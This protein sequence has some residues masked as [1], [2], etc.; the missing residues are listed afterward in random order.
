MLTPPW[1]IH[2]HLLSRTDPVSLSDIESILLDSRG[3]STDSD[4]H[5]FLNPPPPT[6][7]DLRTL[8]GLSIKSLDRAVSEIKAAIET[9]TPILI[10]GDYDCDG[11]CATAILYKAIARHT[12]LVHPFIPHRQHHGYGLSAVG[13]KKALQEVAARFTGAPL[14]ITVDNGISAGL[15]IAAL[16]KAGST[17]IVVDHHQ[18]PPTPPSSINIHSTLVCAATLSLLL[19]SSLEDSL[20]DYELASLATVTDQV[21]LL[22]INRSLVF[23]GLKN[24]RRTKSLGLR[25]LIAAQIPPDTPLDT[26]H[27]GFI[28]GPRINAAGRLDHALIALRLLLTEDPASARRL[29]ERLDD[30]NQARQDHTADHVAVAVSEFTALSTLPPVLLTSSPDYH[31]GII[32][33]IAAKLSD[34]FKRPAVAVRV[35]DVLKGSARSVKGV[36][37]T[38]LLKSLPIDFASIGGHEQAA[39]FSLSREYLDLL[40]NTLNSLQLELPSP[41]LDIDLALNPSQLSLA[42]F[43]LI[44]RF[45]PFGTDN[46]EPLLAISSPIKSLRLVGTSKQHLQ[47]RFDS[48]NISGGI[49]F[50]RPDWFTQISP[51][52]S[53]SLAFHLKHQIYQG[54]S[55]LSLQVR[56]ISQV[57]LSDMRQ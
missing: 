57:S 6:L 27:F 42:L 47:F 43:Q 23:H 37:I 16:Q 39:G 45:A 46:P 4:K 48:P 49:A 24:I 55:Q 26:Y 20:Q 52:R 11:V 7:E 36:D 17:V 2:H 33:L 35:G 22:G 25:T 40:K 44:A 21:P 32:G 51:G 9:K 54:N 14:V 28:I 29:V 18:L 3:L 41:S 15:E 19:A 38:T 56:D 34:T 30:I 12:T 31:G 8:P 50:N 5:N 10:Y 53:F 1:R 13:I